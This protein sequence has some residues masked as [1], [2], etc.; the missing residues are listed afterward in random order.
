MTDNNDLNGERF[1][2]EALKEAMENAKGLTVSLNFN[3][4]DIMGKIVDARL[5]PAGNMVEVDVD[6][7]D[8]GKELLKR[9]SSLYVVPGGIVEKE[10]MDGDVRVIDKIKVTHLAITESPADTHLLELKEKE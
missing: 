3:P 9:L 2:R 10:Y 7:L 5:N 4:N 8:T 6:L 1:S